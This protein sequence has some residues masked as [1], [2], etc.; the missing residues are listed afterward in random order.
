MKNTKFYDIARLFQVEKRHLGKF[1][2]EQLDRC[3]EF[4]IEATKTAA[5]EDNGKPIF[6]TSLKRSSRSGRTQAFSINYF[7]DTE[8]EMHNLNYVASVLLNQKLDKDQRFIIVK[9]NDFEKGKSIIWALSKW[10]TFSSRQR[11]DCITPKEL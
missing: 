3:R 7:N 6:Y 2:V 4:L 11:T 1:Y 10:I 9:T 8:G 5:K